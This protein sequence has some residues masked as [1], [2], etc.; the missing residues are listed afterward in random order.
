MSFKGDRAVVA[1]RGLDDEHRDPE[2]RREQPDLDREQRHDAEPDRGRCRTPV[3]RGQHERDRDQHDR[4]RVEQIVPSRRITDDDEDRRAVRRT[5]SRNRRS[6][7]RSSS[8]TPDMA[9]IREYR[10]AEMMRKQIAAVMCAVSTSTFHRPRPVEPALGER[11]MASAPRRRPRPASVGREHPAV[12]T[13]RAR[14]PRGATIGSIFAAI[15][16]ALINGRSLGRAADRTRRRRIRG[17]RTG[18]SARMPDRNRRSR[19]RCPG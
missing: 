6:C 3:E 9:S 10:L 12:D 16:P 2:G 4:A 11:E 8:V 17:R 19:G 18:P 1:E 5:R 13:A 14:A 7:V 15:S